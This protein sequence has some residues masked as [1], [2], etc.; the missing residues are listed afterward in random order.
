[1]VS[2]PRF[3]AHTAQRT[4]QSCVLVVSDSDAPDSVPE[5]EAV[6]SPIGA[7]D[8]PSRLAL[9]VQRANAER[10]V[11]SGMARDVHARRKLFPES[12][13]SRPDAVERATTNA[14]K[15]VTEL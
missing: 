13:V 7:A 2:P 9:A 11:V 10:Q 14:A 5:P 15:V 12:T 4:G 3:A 8:R 6:P 1:M